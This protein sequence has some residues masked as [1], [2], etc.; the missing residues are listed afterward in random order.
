VQ[1]CMELLFIFHCLTS[2][3]CHIVVDLL[4]AKALRVG[5][6]KNCGPWCFHV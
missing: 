2:M 3:L 5:I 6:A 1:V 4:V